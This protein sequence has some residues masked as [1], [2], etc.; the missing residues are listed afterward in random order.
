MSVDLDNVS[1]TS[2]EASISSSG[3]GWG[4]GWRS[5]GEGGDAARRRHDATT[6]E[7][8]H[9]D[10]ATELGIAERRRCDA[11]TEELLH[12]DAATELGIAERRRLHAAERALLNGGGWRWR[13]KGGG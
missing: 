12:G 11:T 1:T 6:E 2:G 7:L 8:L 3:G 13:K 9:R 5:E 4:R 10:A